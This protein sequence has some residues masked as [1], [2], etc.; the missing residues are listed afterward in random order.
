MK[1]ALYI[2]V[3]LLVIISLFC[4]CSKKESEDKISTSEK[5]TEPFTTGKESETFSSKDGQSEII[6]HRDSEG[7]DIMIDSYGDNGKIQHY[8]EP[9]Y[10]KDG[11]VIG[12]KYYDKN[13]KYVASNENGNKYFDKNGNEISEDEFVKLMSKAGIV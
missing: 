10:D 6:A 9:I 7:N 11:N 5:T 3:C 1:K 12:Y 13:K 8:E 4:S 2:S